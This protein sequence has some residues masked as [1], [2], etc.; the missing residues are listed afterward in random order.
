MADTLFHARMRTP[1]AARYLAIPMSRSPS[2][3][4]RAAAVAY[5]K[6]DLD[7][8]LNNRVRRTTSDKSK[9]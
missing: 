6:I 8:W 1:E 2:S 9:A 7:A 3:R 5:R 4:L